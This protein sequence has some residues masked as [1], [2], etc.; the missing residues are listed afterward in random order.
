MSAV[1]DRFL[2]CAGLPVI[3]E[4]NAGLPEVTEDGRTVY[5]LTPEEFGVCVADFA[6]KG[7]RLVGGCCGTGPEHISA[8]RK[9][10]DNVVVSG[11]PKTISGI[12]LTSRSSLVRIGQDE[13]L[14]FIGERI[15]PTGKKD[16]QSELQAGIFTRALTLASEQ[17]A[18]G[19]P[20][21]DVNVGAPMVDET[22]LLPALTKEL[23]G[24]VQTPLSLDSPNPSAIASALPWYAGSALVNSISGD[25]GRMDVLGTLCKK[26]G[27]PFILLPLKGRKLPVLAQER[28]A[29]IE[30]MLARAEEL[31]IPRHLVLVDALA[32]AVAS[33]PEAA[34][35]GL[36]TIRWC[37]EHGLPTVI[38]LSN[39]SFGLPARE[40]V[41]ATF[42]AMAQG[43]GL[44][45]CIANPMS[46]RMNEARS[47]GDVLLK[48]DTGAVRFVSQYANWSAG[49]AGSSTGSSDNSAKAR[50]TNVR[51]AILAGDRDVIK[52]LV[53]DEITK[54]TDPFALVRDVM[55]PAITEVGDKYGRKE[56]FLPQ[57]LRSA[58]TMQAGFALIKPL[59]EKDG[60]D[61]NH[62]VVLLA[63][64]EG[65]IHDI[66]KN[67]VGLLMGNH[68]FTII[69]LGKDVKAVDIVDA[70]EKY[71]ASIIGLS[72]LMTTTMVRMEETVR[73]VRE[74]G[75]SVNVM[76]G[77]AVV[78][79]TF[80]RRIGASYAADAVEAVRV[81]QSLTGL[82]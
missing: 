58:E 44:S 17:V 75:L 1:V 8:L 4:P 71:H 28:I 62:P 36:K 70:A 13:P 2:A 49:N 35:E 47:A 41:N 32:L 51:D 3:V 42:L 30:N 37:T 22:A 77:G 29:I 78:T 59:L 50:P 67:I 82:E 48:H 43:A 69:D 12:A 80:A 23:V 27:A 25:E 5:R 40:L 81:A 18:A 34:L 73:L 6:S 33:K 57:L 19:V 45:A 15:N 31:G 64:V 26:W 63:T 76:V 52:T 46:V 61:G 66:G 11:E 79:D 24:R 16:L 65:D 68:G 54:G 14:I 21:L 55:I 9:A 60:A 7:A 39:I 72:A 20:V 38:G 56:I 53:Q 74:R 10:L